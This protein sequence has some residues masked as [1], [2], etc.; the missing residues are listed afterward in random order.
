MTTV[1][2]ILRDFGIRP[3]K[4]LGQSFLE[5][6]NVI[7]K[8]LVI[9]DVRADDT[10][11][12]IGAGV[13]IMTELFARKAK[14]VVALDIDPRMIGILRERLADYPHVDVI[15]AN[16]LEYDFS[17]AGTRLSSRKLKIIGNIPYNI[18]SQILFHLLAYRHGISSMILM[19]QKELADRLVAKP[20]TKDYGIPTVLVSMYTECSREMTIPRSCF[21]PQPT[22]TSSVIKMTV[23]GNP[24]IGI[25]DHKLFHE[26]VKA[27]F[28]K[29][30]KTLLNNLRSSHVFGYSEKDIIASLQDAGIDGKR[31]GE[32]LTAEEFGKL[33]N[34][35]LLKEKT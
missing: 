25:H 26:I 4:S 31:R 22:V 32:T 34:V 3:I 6:N 17:F 12:E 23:R 35:L 10:I 11:V 24:L 18:S 2:N 14:K 16:V 21:Y 30:R 5:D 1:R 33:S 15:H 9:S 29:R 20:G 7:N 8:I 27:A 13:G 28:S 19:F